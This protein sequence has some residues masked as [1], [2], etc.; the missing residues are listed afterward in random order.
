MAEKMTSINPKILIWAREVS[1]TTLQEAEEKFGKDKITAWES[2][3]D[4]PTYSQLK[5]LCE[6]YR[7][8][9]VVCFFPEPPRMKN[10]VASCRT[11][12]EEMSHIFS[13]HLVKTIDEARVMQ[14]NLYE[15]N[16]NPVR[17]KLTDFT[18]SSDI[19]EAAKQLRDILGVTLD[20]QK[21]LKRLDEAFEYWRDCFYNIGIYVFKTAFKDMSVSGFWLYDTE[22]PIIYI[23]NS[24]A[25]SRQIFTLFHEIYHLM[26]QTS[27]IDIF[28]DSELNKYLIEQNG[29]IEKNC[30]KFAGTFLVPD[31]DFEKLTLD[32][33]PTD[34]LIQ[35]LAGLY[36][37]SREVILRKFLD[38]GRISSQEYTER[39]EIY[40]Q[41]YFRSLDTK[42]DNQKSSGN[43]YNTQATYKGRH[44][45]ELAFK[46]YYAQ[47][48][49]L[50]QLSTYM[51]MKIPS[52]RSLAEKKGWGT[53]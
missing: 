26:N 20:K 14:L 43:Y 19:K 2:G 18:F 52:V 41:D 51:N 21:E 24:F 1:G 23:N 12:P 11:L 31:D 48:I 38:Y 33:N 15:L 10:I 4:F 34:E 13:R 17:T 6:F 44:Y 3:N 49:N 36:S 29:T 35:R 47:K 25:F 22:F 50:V 32:K 27:G 40:L 7:K 30:N 28:N 16:T 9:V 42:K 8:P 45:L 5:S 39:S 53:L 46:S 37:V